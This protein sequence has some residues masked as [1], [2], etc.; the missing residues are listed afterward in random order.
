[1]KRERAS[2]DPRV[3]LIEHL[4]YLREIGVREIRGGGRPAQVAP[5]RSQDPPRAN[6]PASA[7]GAPSKS[8]ALS[9]L[10]EVE[11]GDCRRCRLC[12]K[13]T[14]IVFGAGSPEARL[15]FVGEGPGHD[16]DLKGVPFVGRA[17]QL[18]TD[19]IGA[20]KL[21]REQ[22]Y[23]ANVVKCR[24]PENR[25]PQPDEIEACRGFLE[26][27]IDIIAPS[28]IV[29]LGAVAV[30]ALLGASGGITKI[31]GAFRE[32]R[33]IPVM[34]T[35]HPA[36]LLRSP[37]KKREVWQDMQQVMRRLVPGSEPG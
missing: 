1:V 20:M 19:I 4:K 37:D 25:T 30:S 17:G 28:V 12:E 9:A 31:R 24:P 6:A 15:M 21:S 22:V 11:I 5:R 13:R 29:C 32:F 10:R 23:I 8:D 36:Y 14:N 27:Q 18:L 33:G 26:R 16:E 3:D 34:P 2:R 35:F 7:R